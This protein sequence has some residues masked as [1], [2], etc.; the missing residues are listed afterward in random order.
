MTTSPAPYEHPLLAAAR[1]VG[2]VLDEAAGSNP[3]FLS[4]GEKHALLVELTWSLGRLAGLRARTLAT[5]DDLAAETGSRDAAAW[6]AVETRTSRREAMRDSRLGT[7]LGRWPQVAAAVAAGAVTWEQADVVMGALEAL[8]ASLERELVTRAEAHLVDEASRFGPRELRV[9]GRRVLEVVAPEIADAEEEAALREEERRARRTTRLSFRPRGDGST[10]LHARLPDHVASRLGAYLDAMTSPRRN[11]PSAA[12]LGDV[13]RLPLPRRRGE[14]FCSLLEQLPADG[15]PQHG[16]TA[17]AVM[18][19]VDLETL[20]SGPGLAETTTGE[21]VT[22]AEARRLACTAGVLPVVLGAKGEVLD[23][24]RSRRLFSPGQRRAMAVRDRRCRAEG[25]DIPAAWCEAQTH[26]VPGLAAATPTWPTASCSAR[27]TTTEPTTHSGVSRAW[28]TVTSATP[29]GRETARGP[30]ARSERAQCDL[31]EQQGQGQQT[32][33]GGKQH[34]PRPLAVPDDRDEAADEGGNR[35]RPDADAP[36]ELSP[37]VGVVLGWF[38]DPERERAHQQG[39]AGEAQPRER[40]RSRCRVRR[41][42]SA[43]GSPP[44][45]LRLSL[46]DGTP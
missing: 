12:P 20:R 24:G 28:P 2:R 35:A 34:R 27:S 4:P 7:S 36:H 19:M 6:L 13:D 42:Q 32:E 18:V 33:P 1:E 22:A 10:D 38:H 8:P 41:R 25:C 37:A 9:L 16:G 46:P 5:S 23:L 15:L 40:D 3:T 11:G 31:R 43:L 30:L 39:D 45:D 44:A 26:G 14:A 17:T 21:V 29:G